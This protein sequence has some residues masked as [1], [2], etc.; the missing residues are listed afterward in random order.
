MFRAED[1]YGV[2]KA[3]MDNLFEKVTRI[4]LPDQAQADREGDRLFDLSEDMLP[5]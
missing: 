2:L 3:H 1:I 4:R 5:F